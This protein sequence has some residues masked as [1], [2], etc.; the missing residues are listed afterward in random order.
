MPRRRRPERPRRT[1][2]HGP[3][4]SDDPATRERAR[5]TLER[6]LDRGA[7][8]AEAA[9]AALR[10][11][12]TCAEAWLL[13]ADATDD[14]AEARRCVREAVAVATVALGRDRLEAERGRLADTADGVAYLHALNALARSQL[15]DDLAAQ[16]VMTWQH[17]LVAD[18]RDPVAVRG[19][20]LLVLL[21]L[22]RD[23]EAED[24]VAAH[25]DEA[26]AHWA[27]ARA[28]LRR[29]RAEDAPALAR[30]TEALDRAIARFPGRATALDRALARGLEG[31][32]E[33]DGMDPLLVGAWADTES[34]S[35]WLAERLEARPAALPETAT[36]APTDGLDAAEADRRFEAMEHV[37]EAREAPPA[38]RE[39]LAERALELWPDCAEAWLVLADAAP[40]PS[41]RLAPLREA[42]G[43][44]RRALRLPARG[45]SVAA[46]D[47]E[48]GRALLRARDALARALRATGDEEGALAEERTLLA[49][50][51][52]DPLGVG[53][54]HVARCFEL[55]RDDAAHGL[56]DARAHDAGPGWVWLRV[57][58][59]RRRGD[60]VAASFAL[61][62]ATMV[63]PFVAALLALGPG[64]ARPPEGLTQDAYA[65]AVRAADTLRPAWAATPGA[66]AWLARTAPPPTPASRG[67]PGAAGR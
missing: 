50:D 24:L 32:R 46:G 67:R 52:D 43:A 53:V 36:P 42:V 58:D 29:R 31:A 62:E 57:L 49:E 41:A 38:R 65:A 1:G 22:G 30:A 25:P 28:L 16:A 37:E 10:V 34:A 12:A 48:D 20:L 15:S 60:G 63:A 9:A 54:R 13:R 61:A 3:G 33:T 2:G 45:A 55:G 19:D 47:G 44:A 4:S 59:A 5:E 23:D 14:P 51:P 6:E 66:L 18:P 21:A 17:V 8:L 26:D 35:A 40:T 39:A 11:S 7:D 64:R 56:L 27:F